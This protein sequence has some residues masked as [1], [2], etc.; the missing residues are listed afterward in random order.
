MKNLRHSSLQM[1]VIYRIPKLQS[2]G[3]DSKLEILIQKIKVEK[4]DFISYFLKRKSDYIPTCT[5][6]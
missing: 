1:N 4:Y 6:E 5:L 2:W 3:H